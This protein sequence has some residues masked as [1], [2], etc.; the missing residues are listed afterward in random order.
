MCASASAAAH[1]SLLSRDNEYVASAALRFPARLRSMGMID[2]LD[3]SNARHAIYWMD[4]RGM[5]G[6]RFHP[7]YYHTGVASEVPGMDRSSHA[8]GTEPEGEIL[9]LPHNEAM[10]DAVQARS[11]IVKLHS[12]LP[13]ILQLDYAARR[14]PG[15][16]WLLDHM[17]YPTPAGDTSQGIDMAANNW[18]ASSQC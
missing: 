11:G 17:A 2:P 5:S 10:F 4:Q 8:S 13:E 3:P 9:K 14:W 15:I 7:G 12:P 18:E 6:F 1:C 16:T